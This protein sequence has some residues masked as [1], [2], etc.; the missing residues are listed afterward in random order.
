MPRKKKALPINVTDDLF[1]NLSG[2]TD[3][4]D[5]INKILTGICEIGE[6]GILSYHERRDYYR[7]I[8]KTDKKVRYNVFGGRML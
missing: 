7:Q 8:G 4:L 6:T 3:I 5:N 1:D 2:V